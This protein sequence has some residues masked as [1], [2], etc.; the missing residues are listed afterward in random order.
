MPGNK[1]H[2]VCFDV[3]APPDYGGAIDLYYKIKSLAEAGCGIYL[4]CFQYGREVAAELEQWCEQV[5]YYPRVTGLAGISLQLPYIVSSRKSKDLLQRLKAIDA[6]ILFEGL[7]CCL[8]S[9]HP[10]LAGRIKALRSHNV[11]SDYYQKLAD[12]ERSPLKRIYFRLE[13][14]RL[15]RFEQQLQSITHFF[16]LSENDAAWFRRLYP[17]A[18]HQYIAPFHPFDSVCTKSGIGTFLLYHGNLGHPEN[19]EAAFFLLEEVL[20]KCP[21]PI[22]FAGRNPHPLLAERIATC[23]NARLVANPDALTMAS[24]LREAHAHLLPTFQA[25][26]MK[27]KLLYALF[28]G[29]HILANPAMVSG[30]GL[31]ELCIICDDAQDWIHQIKRIADKAFTLE[32]IAARERTL[33]LLYSNGLN[34]I[35]L[36]T[37]L[38]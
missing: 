24:L 2:I 32:M 12:K 8:Y 7:H 15:Q 25:T 35:R 38:Q 30:T 3:P 22:V 29:R 27:L 5:W 26:G 17:Q 33:N 9:S 20:G 31:R 18:R 34:A 19:I 37:S 10:A 6:P 4:H 14:N 21:M 23:N 16:A 36:L 28:G 13:S 11:E 1:L